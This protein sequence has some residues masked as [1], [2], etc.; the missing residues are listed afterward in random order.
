MKDLRDR[1][2]VVTGAASGI[3]LA[4]A[5]AFARQG[6]RVHLVDL[7]ADRLK[8]AARGITVALANAHVVDCSDGQAVAGLADEIFSAEGRVDVLHNNAGVCCGGPA[9]SIPLDDWRLSIDVNLWG[10]I[11][12][13]RAFVPRMIEAGGGHVINTASMAGL[14]GLPFVAPYCA[15]KFAVVGLSES[16][17]LELAAHNIQVTTVCPGA[18]RTNVLDGGRL[19]LPGDWLGRIKSLVARHGADPE[20]VAAQIVDAVRAKRGMLTPAAG[21]MLPMWLLKRLSNG[22][23]ARLGRLISGLADRQ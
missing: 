15:S 23:Y 20:Q 11:H 14:I 18:V 13:V 2:V 3:G 6:S 8:D 12:G 10:V 19:E 1:V 4:T 16:L 5:R 9:C 22:L 7:N 21:G 17:A